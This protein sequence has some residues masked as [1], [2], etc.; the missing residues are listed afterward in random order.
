MI[1]T[2]ESVPAAGVR[3]GP[4]R[5]FWEPSHYRSELGDLMLDTMLAGTCDADAL[6]GEDLLAP[7]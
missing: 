1:F 5:W 4:L 7:R 3:S 2:E 6:I